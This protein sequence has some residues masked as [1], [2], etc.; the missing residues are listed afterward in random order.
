MAFAIVYSNNKSNMGS[1]VPSSALRWAVKF[2]HYNNNM[3]SQEEK[4]LLKLLKSTTQPA[5]IL[6]NVYKIWNNLLTCITWYGHW[7]YSMWC[8]Q[9]NAAKIALIGR[10]RQYKYDVCKYFE[11]HGCQLLSLSSETAII[12]TLQTFTNHNPWDRWK[13]ISSE[14]KV[15]I[16][17]IYLMLKRGFQDGGDDPLPYVV[18]I[19][20]QSDKLIWTLYLERVGERVLMNSSHL[21]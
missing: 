7:P 3:I 12:F 13:L 2:K 8:T 15:Y 21:Q 20:I 17:R 16:Q 9:K 14:S 19:L 11:F 18:I 6:I 5:P 1:L 10:R 4:K